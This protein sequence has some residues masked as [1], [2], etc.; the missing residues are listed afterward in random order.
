MDSC[1]YPASQQSLSGVL[2][3]KP[4]VDTIIQTL[5]AFLNENTLAQ[6]NQVQIVWLL[7]A[8][9]FCLGLV[10]YRQKL[11]PFMFLF[12]LFA[13]PFLGELIVSIRRPIFYDRTLIWVTIPL[14]LI[15][16]TGIAQL[17]FRILIIMALGF[18]STINLFSV[19]DYYRFT[20][21]E[22]WSIAAGYVA[23]FAE[24]DDLILF[25]AAW[26][27]IPSTIILRPMKTCILFR[28]RSMA[29]LKTCS[30]ATFWNRK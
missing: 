2:M 22:D 3:P 26:V 20:Q 21:K 7:Y 8:V 18:F 1:L 16:A 12:A 25:H 9:V 13:I 15:L 27:Q 24:K 6:A 19:G 4:T 29:F 30:Q 14:F 11:S 28:W 23:N 17:R 5:R 10:H